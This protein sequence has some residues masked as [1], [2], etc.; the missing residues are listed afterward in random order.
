MIYLK[1]ILERADAKFVDDPKD[2][3][4]NLSPENI[5]KDTFINMLT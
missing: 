2:A 1:E 4:I 3:D 5:E